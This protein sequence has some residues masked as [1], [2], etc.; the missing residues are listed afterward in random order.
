MTRPLVNAPNFEL[1]S[2][3]ECERVSYSLCVGFRHALAKLFGVAY[4]GYFVVDMGFVDRD[5]AFGMGSVGTDS[6]VD[7][8]YVGAS[9]VV[10]TGSTD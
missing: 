8:D 6:V 7:K 10:G 5:S 4:V 3:G 1:N 9:S 2:W